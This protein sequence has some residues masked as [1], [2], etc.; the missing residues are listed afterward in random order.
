MRDH[1][2]SREITQVCDWL[3]Q[4]A[5][6]VGVKLN[7]RLD[8]AKVVSGGRTIYGNIMLPDRSGNAARSLLP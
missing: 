6:I 4:Y 8:S 1:V 2:R 5:W 3:G 7:Q